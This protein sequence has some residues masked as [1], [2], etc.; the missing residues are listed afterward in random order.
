MERH[1]S[2]LLEILPNLNI[3]LLPLQILFRSELLYS[4]KREGVTWRLHSV[5]LPLKL[6]QADIYY[7]EFV[8]ER[9]ILC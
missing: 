7:T 4:V 8:V 5:F 3:K 2:W 1:Y 9:E 6:I